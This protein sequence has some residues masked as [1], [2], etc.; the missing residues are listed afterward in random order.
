M[1][2]NT[3]WRGPFS[4]WKETFRRW[5]LDPEARTSIEAAVFFDLRF[6]YGEPALVEDLKASMEQAMRNES[7][8]LHFLARN[9]VADRSSPS[10]LRS[11]VERFGERSETL[12]IKR[13]GIAPLVNIARLFAMQLRY[14]DSSNTLDRFRHAAKALPEMSKTIETSQR[15]LQCAGRA[16]LRSSSREIER[17]EN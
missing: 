12:D 8:F 14:L 16:S 11:M 17:G 4:S 5:I 2:R 15:S 13:R 6:L 9:A 1:A 3:K 10:L 7:R